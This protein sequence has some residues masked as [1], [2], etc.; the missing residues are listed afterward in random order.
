MNRPSARS[1]ASPPRVTMDGA[2]LRSPAVVVRA[3]RTGELHGLAPGEEPP[4]GLAAGMRLLCSGHGIEVPVVR[5]YAGEFDER[6]ACRTCLAV[7]RGEPPHAPATEPLPGS[8]PALPEQPAAVRLP[9]EHRGRAMTWDDREDLPWMSHVPR[10]C[11]ACGDVGP[12]QWA[13]GSGSE[14]PARYF[15]V[16]CAACGAARAFTHGPDGAPV[17]VWARRRR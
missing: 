11:E 2:G 15:A 14:P 13:Q 6:R 9:Q 5:P 7:A 3:P 17:V 10:H 4:T 12:V 16:Q 1:Q 8:E